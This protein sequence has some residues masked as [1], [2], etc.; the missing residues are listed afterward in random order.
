MSGI[1]WVLAG[2]QG[3]RIVQH[4][5]HLAVKR[6]FQDDVVETAAGKVPALA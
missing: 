1:W 6:P 4:W 2:F 5:V 3:L